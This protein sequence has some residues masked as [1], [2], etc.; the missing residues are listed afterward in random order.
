MVCGGIDT[1]SP[2]KPDAVVRAAEAAL[3]SPEGRRA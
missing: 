1:R 3:V 2:S